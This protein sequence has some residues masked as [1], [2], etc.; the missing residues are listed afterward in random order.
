MKERF[1][2]LL[3]VKSIM[4]LALTATFVYLAVTQVI[5]GDKYYDIYLMIVSFYFGT[6]AKKD[7]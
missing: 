1:S 7:A 2:K 4:T 6:Q 3:S 5:A